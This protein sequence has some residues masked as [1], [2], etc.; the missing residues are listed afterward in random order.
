MPKIRLKN[1]IKNFHIKDIEDI[2]SVEIEYVEY[3]LDS[4]GKI[5]EDIKLESGE[6][7]FN[8]GINKLRQS[9]K[10]KKKKIMW[11]KRN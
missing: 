7:K 11:I 3:E 10:D 5:R 8:E 2:E 4:S 9:I 1:L 6:I